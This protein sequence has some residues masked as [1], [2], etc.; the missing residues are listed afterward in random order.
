MKT[1]T[2]TASTDQPEELAQAPHVLA[3]LVDLLAGTLQPTP[4]REAQIAEHLA[5]CTSCQV[6]VELSLLA[7]LKDERERDKPSDEAQTLLA[8]LSRIRHATLKEE[9]LAYVEAQLEQGEQAA[10]ARFPMLADHLP[11]CQECREEVHNLR[12]WLDLSV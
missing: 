9:I 12:S 5:E 1:H 2:I 7:I 10:N 4:E 11:T 8:R 3:Q 6:F